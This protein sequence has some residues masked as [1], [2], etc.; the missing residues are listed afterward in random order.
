[1]SALD[2]NGFYCRHFCDVINPTGKAG[3]V[4]AAAFANGKTG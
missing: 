4:Y 2:L 1:M 3:S